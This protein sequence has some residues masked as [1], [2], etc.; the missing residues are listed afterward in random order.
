MKMKV[1]KTMR[2]ESDYYIG[3][4]LYTFFILVVLSPLPSIFS[5]LLEDS[6]FWSS[7]LAS[8]YLRSALRTLERLFDDAFSF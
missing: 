1:F 8:E 4:K 7:F 2:P 6:L 3:M 5:A